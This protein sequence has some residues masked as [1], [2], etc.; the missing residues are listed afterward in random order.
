M[1]CPE[2]RASVRVK[3]N[4]GARS[5]GNDVLASRDGFQDLS[6]ATVMLYFVAMVSHW[7]PEATRWNLSQFAGTPG[8]VGPGADPVVVVVVLVVV[9]VVLVVVVVGLVVVDFD[10]LNVV[11]VVVE[12]VTVPIT[13]YFWP[14]VR[15]G[16]ETLGLSAMKASRVCPHTD[17]KESQVS[18]LAAATE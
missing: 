14:T 15:S 13:Q 9:V 6:C 10:V 12:L 3:G 5:E 2:K 8:W 11:L 16:Q 7:S 17:A 1:D 18:P 4:E